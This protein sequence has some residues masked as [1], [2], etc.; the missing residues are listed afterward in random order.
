MR[1][2]L[3]LS[4]VFV[5]CF[6][7]SLF[8]ALPD[9]LYVTDLSQDAAGELPKN[10]KLTIP[11]KQHSSTSYIVEYTGSGPY[12]HTSSNS[13]GSWIENNLN[14]ISVNDYPFIEWEWMVNI[15]P[16]VD[17]E[18]NKQNDD[19]AVR[20]ELVFDYKGGNNPLNMLRK[21]LITSLF[22]HNPPELV[23]SYVWAEHVPVD[24]GYISPSSSRM[25]IIPVESDNTAV[26]RW[27]HERRNVREDL[28]KYKSEKNLFLKK[29][30]IRTDAENSGSTADSGVRNIRLLSGNE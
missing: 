15:F 9:T 23:I 29:I 27:I 10:W 14:D 2:I 30:R 24:E 18:R 28:K 8:A 19:F 5:F 4:T 25:V 1:N 11:P 13:A 16:Q 26:R 6:S 21:G 12:I 3:F 20:V 17:W 7:E 22:K